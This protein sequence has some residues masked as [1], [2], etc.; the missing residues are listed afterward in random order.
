MQIVATA[1]MTGYHPMGSFHPH[2]YFG[3]GTSSFVS[4]TGYGFQPHLLPQ[5]MRGVA[6]NFIMPYHHQE[7]RMN[8]IRRIGNNQVIM[9]SKVVFFIHTKLYLLLN[10]KFF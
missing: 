7:Q 5:G 2:I 10:L 1:G 8:T 3:S 9:H 4:P 6:P